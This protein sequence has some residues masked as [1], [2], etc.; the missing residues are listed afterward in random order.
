MQTP[1]TICTKDII[2]S[3]NNNAN[4]MVPT[5]TALELTFNAN[6]V[7]N[8]QIK[9]DIQQDVINNVN[10]FI[11]RWGNRLGLI[12]TL[13]RGDSDALITTLTP[14]R[15]KDAMEIIVSNLMETIQTY[16][17]ELQGSLD[18]P[19]TP[20]AEQRAII[21]TLI[22]LASIQ[23]QLLNNVKDYFFTNMHDK[24]LIIMYTSVNPIYQEMQRIT[25]T[26]LTPAQK[27]IALRRTLRDID[28]IN[29]MAAN[30]P[31]IIANY[32]TIA[33]QTEILN[34]LNIIYNYTLEQYLSE[35]NKVHLAGKNNPV[36]TKSIN[37]NLPTFIENPVSY[38]TNTVKSYFGIDLPTLEDSQVSAAF[39][40]MGHPAGTNL[41]YT[42]M[43]SAT[44]YSSSIDAAN[45]FATM[46][47]ARVPVRIISY[48]DPKMLGISVKITPQTTIYPNEEEQLFFNNNAESMTLYMN[49]ILR[50]G[51]IVYF[52]ANDIYTPSVDFQAFNTALNANAPFRGQAISNVLQG[53]LSPEGCQRHIAPKQSTEN[54]I[55]YFSRIG[56]LP[57]AIHIIERL[58]N[59]N[60]QAQSGCSI[61]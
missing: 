25:Y 1:T 20:L 58:T 57:E 48:S 37:S 10:N 7:L 61:S 4:F 30:T 16:K 22:V 44:S 17:T 13:T 5:M 28:G 9:D 56:K 2:T 26:N 38:V 33:E 21:G 27:A 45:T 49:V 42:T 59:S 32:G 14:K 31:L 60:K 54:N 43:G 41:P 47:A 55:E 19:V 11:N 23:M 34:Q 8:R 53:T 12:N 18:L 24:A 35:L 40:G 6:P 29:D 52:N 46:S 36:I 15:M 3:L 39:R 50:D 51:T